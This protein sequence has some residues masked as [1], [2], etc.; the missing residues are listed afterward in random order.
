MAELYTCREVATY[1]RVKT[2]TV[3]EWIRKGKLPA[4]KLGK[5]YRISKEDMEKF[6]RTLKGTP[7]NYS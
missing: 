2:L 7:K 5:E 6:E 3:W 4:I 1:Y